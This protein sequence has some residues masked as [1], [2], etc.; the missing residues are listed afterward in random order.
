MTLG[1]SPTTAQV[2]KDLESTETKLPGAAA[3]RPGAN[4]PAIALLFL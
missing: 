1:G 4:W 2:V 3:L